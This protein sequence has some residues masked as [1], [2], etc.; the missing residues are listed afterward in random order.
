MEKR[1]IS[2]HPVFQELMGYGL[3]DSGQTNMAFNVYLDLTEVKGFWNVRC[4]K[5]TELGMAF[6]SGH[7][8]RSQPRELILPVSCDSQLSPAQMQTYIDKVKV[9]GYDTVGLVMAI[10]S[11]D[12]GIVY[13]KVTDGLIVPESPEESEFKRQIR[14]NRLETERNHVRKHTSDYIKE[15]TRHNDN[16]NTVN[17]SGDDIE[18]DIDNDASKGTVGAS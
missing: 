7:M 5:C 15:R 13:Y 18:K 1:Q 9:D 6:L 2:E 17:K 4:H 3:A 10:C 12:S 8:S 16:I 11:G 14:M